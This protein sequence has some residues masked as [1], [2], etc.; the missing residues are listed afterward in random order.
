M[1]LKIKYRRTTTFVH[2]L[3]FIKQGDWVDLAIAED[4]FLTSKTFKPISLGIQM[5]LPKGFE[6]W[7]APRSSTGKRYRVLIYNSPGVCDESYRGPQDVWHAL[8]FAPYGCEIKAG[9]DICQF[10]IMPKMQ[11]PIWT[12]IKWLFVNKIEFVEVEDLDG[13][14]RGG[15]GSTH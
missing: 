13:D 6:A 14:N 1:T 9:T 15:L 5:H 7:V 4:A 3:K 10:R 2:P 12:R 11:A 8:I